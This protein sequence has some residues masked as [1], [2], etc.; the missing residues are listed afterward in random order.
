MQLDPIYKI[1]VLVWFF[2]W[3]LL[4]LMAPVPVFRLF[5]WGR[6]PIDKQL[7][8]EKW[9]GRMAIAFGL[10]FVIELAFRIVK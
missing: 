1:V 4:F 10:L 7:R 2:G 8:R 6:T 9:L 3:G 5:T